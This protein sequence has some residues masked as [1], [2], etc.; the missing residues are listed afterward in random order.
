MTPMRACPATTVEIRLTGVRPE[1]WDQF[2]P[3]SAHPANTVGFARVHSRVDTTPLFLEAYAGTDKVAQWLVF[4]RFSLL[5]PL[6]RRCF[7]FCAPQ[8]H[9]D[10]PGLREAVFLAYVRHLLDYYKAGDIVL[11]SY[12]LLRG[13]SR[14]TL[15]KAGFHRTSRFWSYVNVLGSDESL[16]RTFSQNHRLNARKAQKS[17]HVYDRELAPGEYL[18][19]SRETYGAFG[20]SGPSAGLVGGIS[21]HMVPR[22]TALLSGVRV[23]R[24]LQAASVVLYAG[25]RAYFLHGASRRLK[26]RSAATF[27][28]FENMR[29]LRDRGVQEYDFGGA[30]VGAGHP[31]K[32][33]SI[34]EFKRKFGGT[35]VELF[36]GS[37]R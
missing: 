23:G 36:G 26:D 24:T 28:H 7:A 27:L 15:E 11:E 14:S 13:L 9:G 22:G 8:V 3:G 18:D 35:P 16:L 12:A 5:H 29:L 2:D 33:V 32:A 31:A 30:V 25:R 19:V 37:Y 6:R 10:W 34:S 21:A 20:Q 17:G 1:N 4:R